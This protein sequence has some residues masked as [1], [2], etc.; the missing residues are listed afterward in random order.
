[1]DKDT[2]IKFKQIDKSVNFNTK[3]SKNKRKTFEWEICLLSVSVCMKVKVKALV[4]QSCWI[5]WDS[6]V[7]PWDFPGKNTGVGCHSLLQGI[8][9][10]QGSNLG[11]L[12]VGRFFAVWANREAHI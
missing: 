8:F 4:A 9:P 2:H 11:L 12:H 10:T 7:W 3:Q 5:I 6:M 1:M